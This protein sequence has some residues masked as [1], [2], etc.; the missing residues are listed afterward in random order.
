MSTPLPEPQPSRRRFHAGQKPPSREAVAAELQAF[1]GPS[2]AA[3]AEAPIA[4]QEQSDPQVLARQPVVSVI[5]LAYRHEPFVAQA[6]EA[7]VSQRCDFPFELIIGE[8]CSPDRTRE[9]CLAYQA[10]YPHIIRVV[11]SER[12]L[13]FVRN[14]AR[15]LTRV[16]G[17][18]L[19]FCEG[20]DYWCDRD[21][22]QKQVSFLRSRPEYGMI[23]ASIIQLEEDGRMIPPKRRADRDVYPSILFN[24]Y[25]TCTVCVRTEL[26]LE[27]VRDVRH[28]FAKEGMGDHP[29]WLWM[30]LFSRGR[31]MGAPASVYRVLPESASHSR[32]EER[33]R[34]FIES[35]NRIAL[36]F[37]PLV[38]SW[39]RQ[40]NFMLCGHAMC[41]GRWLGGGN[42][43]QRMYEER[44]ARYASWFTRAYLW[45]FRKVRGVLP[46]VADAYA[47]LFYKAVH[48]TLRR[49]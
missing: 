30:G 40:L 3:V 29:C 48:G 27:Y 16:R 22:L 38:P 34:R 46:R 26:F 6:I 49:F 9:I 39:Q 36:A 18:Y 47:R 21:K 28:F 1:F 12:N 33:T 25:P 23:G 24:W 32:S 41:A 2:E 43:V 19:A 7:V 11:Y 4:S 20:D 45:C 35:A 37:V 5:M 44:Y 8:D 14:E 13:G 31:W 17:Q 10:K 42:G 15:C